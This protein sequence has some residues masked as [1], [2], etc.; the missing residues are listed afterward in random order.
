MNPLTAAP[1][2]PSPAPASAKSGAPANDAGNGESN[3]F[4]KALQRRQAADG[5]AGAQRAA[6]PGP[7]DPATPAD[8]GPQTLTPKRGTL[9]PEVEPA[10][11]AAP[12]AI[13]AQPP[14]PGWPPAGLAGL[15]GFA[16]DD[17]VP[18]SEP[19]LSTP[20]Q[21]LLPE[22]LGVAGRATTPGQAAIAA[23]PL[24]LAALP[25]PDE[26]LL[27]VPV[28]VAE[29]ALTIEGGEPAPV[30]FVL[31]APA[32]LREPPPLL[33]TPLPTPHVGAEDFEAQFGAQLEWMADR[34]ISEARIRVTPNDLG[35]VEVRLHL[36]GDRIRAD[37]ISA[38]SETRQ[39]LE[40]GMPRLRDLLGEHGF[41]LAHANVGSGQTGTGQSGD[42]GPGRSDSTPGD[43]EGS[44]T[45]APAP[46][47][48][49]LGLLD[50]YA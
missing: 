7:E 24:S 37:F 36:D 14:V 49:T 16:D 38:N 23:A 39:A 21:A 10:A 18:L 42:S 9:A 20:A 33:A 47:A 3:A 28:L 50:A 44:G 41:Q 29:Q 27:P 48:R 30:T 34:K 13:D 26:A 43:D 32:P 8:M 45:L 11:P 40:H 22:A 17:A 15:L 31:P 4:A 35:P 12:A 2:T 46:R 19:Q 5:G 6:S 1:P 25:A